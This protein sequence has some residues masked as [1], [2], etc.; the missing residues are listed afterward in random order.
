MDSKGKPTVNVVNEDGDGISNYNNFG[1]FSSWKNFGETISG[2]ESATEGGGGNGNE[3]TG[4][5]GQRE[6]VKDM[7]KSSTIVKGI[8]V[9]VYASSLLFGPEMMIPGTCIYNF[10]SK[11][12]DL[13]TAAQVIYDVK[14]AQNGKSGA[15]SNAIVGAVSLIGGKVVGNSIEKSTLDVNQKF[16]TKVIADKT[17]DVVKEKS[18]KK[19]E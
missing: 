18:M 6:F 16:M 13:S 5:K 11:M 19:V 14:D 9:G 12:D 1:D 8:G 17:I 10:G 3:Y 4:E 2:L 15:G 7:G